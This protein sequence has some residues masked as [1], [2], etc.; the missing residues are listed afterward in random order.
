MMATEREDR[1]DGEPLPDRRPLD[2]QAELARA[3][4]RIAELTSEMQRLRDHVI[5]IAI[6]QAGSNEPDDM[7]PLKSA[8]RIVG[9]P[10]EA[11]RRLVA[12]G[13][14]ASEQSGKGHRIRVSVSSLLRAVRS[15]LR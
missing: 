2:I 7:K 10:Y 11:A 5:E 12:A 15:R 9:T 13:L 3:H 8:S 4:R 6:S 1:P 14:V